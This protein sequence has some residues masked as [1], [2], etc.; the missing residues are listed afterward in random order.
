[1]ENTSA[2]L[3][4]TEDL[5]GNKVDLQ[6]YR[7]EK[8]LLSFFRYAA[9][10]F[11]NLRLQE[12]IYKHGDFKEKGLKMIALFESPRE[13]MLKFSGQRKAPFPI[14]PDPERTIYSRYGVVNSSKLGMVKGLTLG[15]PRMMKAM[16]NGYFPG[17]TEGDAYLMPADFLIGPGFRIETAYYGRDIGDHLPL[18]QIENWLDKNK[19]ETAGLAEPANL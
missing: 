8:I 11:C 18:N 12:L 1:M 14:I 3:F 2:Y 15:M 10:P 4:S 19:P 9:C 5:H 6:D 13:S 16:G 7:N 17:K